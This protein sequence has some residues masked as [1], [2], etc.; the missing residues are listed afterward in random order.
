MNMLRITLTMGLLA[1]VGCN[2]VIIDAPFGE[3]LNPKQAA[4]FDGKWSDGEGN[5]VEFHLTKEGK[6]IAGTISWDDDAQQFIANNETIDTRTVGGVL[7]AFLTE[8]AVTSFA[9]IE[10]IDEA[11]IVAHLPMPPK[12]RSAVESGKL[13]GTVKVRG[14]HF[15]VKLVADDPSTTAFLAS[16][17]WRS[18]YSDEKIISLTRIGKPAEK[19][20]E[21]PEESPA[22]SE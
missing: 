15:T 11:Q 18:Y 20:E 4:Q 5:V 6:L 9:R 12:F 13:A 2:R 19:T 10:M 22:T 8:D 14:E 16:E 3:P 17:D 1:F 21:T 7:Y